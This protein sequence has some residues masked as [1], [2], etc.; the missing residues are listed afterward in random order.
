MH[1][2][3]YSVKGQHR[4]GVDANL[5]LPSS[6]LSSVTS[7]NGLN[8]AQAKP[9]NSGATAAPTTVPPPDGLP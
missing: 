7:V 6:I 4:R 3:V 8:Q 1:L 9:L 5:S 2:N